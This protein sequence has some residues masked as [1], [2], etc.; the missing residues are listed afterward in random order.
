MSDMTFSVPDDLSEEGKM[1]AFHLFWKEKLKA[2]E[3][4]EMED[5][6]VKGVG[7]KEKS[8]SRE[9]IEGENEKMNS[10]V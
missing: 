3:E 10:V 4:N 9:T 5:K 7:D 2:M 8:V 6:G 1:E